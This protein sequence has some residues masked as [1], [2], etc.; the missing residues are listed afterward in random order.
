MQNK[1]SSWLQA[2]PQRYYHNPMPARPT[3]CFICKNTW[4]GKGPICDACLLTARGRSPLCNFCG[5]STHDEAHC[6]GSKLAQ[7]LK[8]NIHR[9][10][11]MPR[12]AVRRSKPFTNYYNAPTDPPLKLCSRCNQRTCIATKAGS[13]CTNCKVLTRTPCRN[14]DSTATHG[15]SGDGTQLIECNDCLFIE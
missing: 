8:A 11:Y 7:Q 6:L 13:I 1:R 2:L 15:L 5:S 3:N 12:K 14:C 4:L 9:N 10:T